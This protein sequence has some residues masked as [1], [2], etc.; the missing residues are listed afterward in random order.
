M[1]TRSS[2]PLRIRPPTVL[3]GVLTLVLAQAA[4]GCMVSKTRYDELDTAF[5]MESQAHRQTS[6]R[7]YE[8]E[9]KLANLWAV[10]AEREQRLAQNEN[11]LA[12]RE[13]DTARAT[14]ERESADGL[15]EQL[16]NDLARVGD[17]LRIFGEQKAG[18]EEA[19]A[20]A[21]VRSQR[22][23][24][25]E[26]NAARSALVLRDL[27]RELRQPLGAG[28]I[29]VDLELGRP[30]VR[31]DRGKLLVEG[32]QAIVPSAQEMLAGLTRVAKVHPGA[33]LIVS[34][35]SDAT[36][37]QSVARLRRVLEALVAQGIEPGRVKIEMSADQKAAASELSAFEA[38]N[39]LE[40]A[41]KAAEPPQATASEDMLD[42][43]ESP[44][45]DA[46]SASAPAA[47]PPASAEAASPSQAPRI[48][49]A[50]AF[51]D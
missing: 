34:E 49:I 42:P 18:L 29:E 37:E 13:L 27:A 9:Q 10:L 12:E 33:H 2:S 40:R 7:L 38:Q 43:G 24:A 30:L 4:A 36:P 45:E 35:R 19:L 32:D 25:A 8:I 50:L 15:V 41:V 21:E 3:P 6:A 51:D 16:R 44:S 39:E 5:R 14:Q 48:V 20:A 28:E 46:K 17:H 47:P 1:K 26:R 23:A 11:Q 22:I 31:I